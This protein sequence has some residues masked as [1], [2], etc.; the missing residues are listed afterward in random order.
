LKQVQKYTSAATFATPIDATPTDGA[1]SGNVFRL[2]DPLT[3]QWQFNLDTRAK[4]M[5]RGGWQIRVTLADRTLHT[6]FIE[7]K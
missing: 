1:T 4:G 6:A 2:T 3:G 7:L 5:S